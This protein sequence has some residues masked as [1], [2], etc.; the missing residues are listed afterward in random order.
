LTKPEVDNFAAHG[1][2]EEETHFAPGTSLVYA[3]QSAHN[4]QEFAATFSGHKITVLIPE[5]SR[6]RWTSTDLTGFDE[7]VDAGQGN[8]LRLVIE[9]DW[10]CIDNTMNEDQSENYPNPGVKC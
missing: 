6:K 7:E 1:Y 10:A 5:E 3:L 4:V 9:K 8:R 2:L